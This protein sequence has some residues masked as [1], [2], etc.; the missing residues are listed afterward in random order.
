M[1]RAEAQLDRRIEDLHAGRLRVWSIIVSFF[2][3]AITPR[4]GVLWLSTFR[5]LAAR[6]GIESGALG[7][8]L[9]R[10]TADGWLVREK[11]GRN[12]L[13]RLDA[14][15]QS[16]FESATEQIYGTRKAAPWNGR[17]TIVVGP[18]EAPDEPGYVQIDA[19]TWARPEY[20]AKSTSARDESKGVRFFAKSDMSPSLRTLVDEAWNLA[21]VAAAYE[22]WSARYAPLAKAL[23]DSTPLEPLSAMCA[24][25]L[26][27]H[28]FRRVVLKDPVLP[29]DLRG[30]DWPGFVARDQAAALYARLIPASEA[31]LD[32]SDRT[33]EGPLPRPRA[34]FY[35]RFGGLK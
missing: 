11:R 32:A 16:A 30:A 27:I 29:D 12:T 22:R 7:A 4:G 25:L 15:G 10:L 33:P 20:G 21:P 14:A 31:W 18:S 35:K 8:A 3:D 2:G 9:S 26:L 6:L 24:R 28:D 23:E 34:S 19:R 5:P 17:W 13:Y 1:S